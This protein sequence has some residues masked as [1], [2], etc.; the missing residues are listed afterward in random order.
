MASVRGSLPLGTLANNT[1]V[2]KDECLF[3]HNTPANN[4]QGLAICLHCFKGFCSNHI[5]LHAGQ[6]AHAVYLHLKK[7]LIVKA[8]DDEV[9]PT[10][11]KVAIGVEGGVS[12]YKDEWDVKTSVRNYFIDEA[13]DF[14]EQGDAEIATLVEAVLATNSVNQQAEVQ[15]WEQ[16]ITECTHTLNLVQLADAPKLPPKSLSHCGDCELSSNL[17]LCMTCGHLGCGRRNFDGSGGN[18]HGVSHFEQSGHPLVCKMGTVTAEGTADLYCYA[19]DDP[20]KDS[21]LEV[22]FGHFGIDL[23]GCTKTEATTGEMELKINLDFAFS[24]TDDLTLGAPVFGQ[25]FTGMNNIGNSCYLASVVQ[26]LFNIPAFRDAYRTPEHFEHCTADN[27]SRCFRCQF[28]KLQDGLW[29][30]RY[31]RPSQRPGSIDQEGIYP[32][33]FKYF[34]AGDNPDWNG[35]DQ[36]DAYEYFQHVLDLIQRQDPSGPASTFNFQ[37]EQ[38]VECSSCHHVGY[39]TESSSEL[40]VT[41]PQIAP[42]PADA[43][44]IGV[45]EHERNTFVPFSEMLSASFFPETITFFCPVCKVQTSAQKSAA[46]R[47]APNHLAV[48]VRRQ[49]LQNWVPRKVHTSI[50]VSQAPL[51]LA[52]FASQRSNTTGELLFPEEQQQSSAEV[53]FPEAVLNALLGMG[54]SE[55]R[56]KHGMLSSPAALNDPEAAM[57]WIFSTMDEAKYDE[58]VPSSSSSSAPGIQFPEDVL[59]TLLGMG[60]SENRCKHGMLS[61]PAALNNAEAAMEWIF[62]T[63]DDP[64]YEE[65]PSAEQLAGTS[66]SASS[67][68][69]PE[70]PPEVALARVAASTF[71]L[72]GFI[73]H[74][75]SSIHSGHYIAYLRIAGVW[76]QFNDARVRLCPNPP[77]NQAYMLFFERQD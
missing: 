10:P 58:P 1:A 71:S 43:S 38:R 76:H 44:I 35:K 69:A 29:S 53:H 21:K 12:V 41:L 55:N 23:S 66:S 59:N 19:C 65:A 30:G 67:S 57:E 77:L 48:V 8:T 6:T 31:S 42:A 62:T 50:E 63:M 28:T 40:P 32:H 15:A 27:P 26:N 51:S 37:L 34:V 11:T 60:F 39:R 7:T 14:L 75:G 61:S 9:A 3:C 68:A 74:R 46:L 24:S 47:S 18:G 33:S 73:E 25:G 16:V 22:H 54:F 17:W 52:A 4:E 36:Q 20:T 45:V 5:G 56:C 49:E 13:H 64:A 2:F 70:E 72:I